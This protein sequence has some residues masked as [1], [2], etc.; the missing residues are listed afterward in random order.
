MQY[1][2]QQLIDRVQSHANGFNGW[3]KGVYLIAVRSRADVVDVFDDKGYLFVCPADGGRPVFNSVVTCTTNAGS[4]G[5][6]HFDDIYHLRGCAVLKSDQIVY[7]S[8]L[9]GLHKGYVAY[10]QS[11]PFPYFRDPNKND[12]A[13]EI[14]PEHND[15]IFA[16]VHRANP[17]RISTVIK[18]WSIACIVMNDPDQFNA[19][20]AFMNG[21][22]L[23]LCILKEF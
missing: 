21:R 10:R 20:M 4:D 17:K 15:I 16:D 22:P 14:G 1:S 12:K 2:D 19:F 9:K 8:H 5:L 11:K 18:N 6:R 23:S 7:N 3:E 13:E